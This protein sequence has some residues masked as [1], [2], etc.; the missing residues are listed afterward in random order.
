MRTEFI[1]IREILSEVY[2]QGGDIVKDITE[3]D[4]I[5]E[6]AELI[7]VVGMP[8]LFID[9]TAELEIK[10]N[11]AVLPCDIYELK[12]VKCGNGCGTLNASTDMFNVED[13]KTNVPTYKVQGN[14]LVVS[15]E[16]GTVMISYRAFV[17]DEDGS[18]MIPD[19]KT[20]TRALISYVIYKRVYQDYINGKVPNENIMER[21]ERNY[22][23]NISQASRRFEQPTIDETDNVRRMMNSFIFRNHAN[24]LGYKNIGDVNI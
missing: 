15:F 7:G 8:A 22:E 6:T 9:K 12:Q 5:M 19:D 23:F 17:L 2:R 3:E 21:V 1:S 11:R 16:E 24:K 13:S 18:P 4:V 20:F 10:K 14:I